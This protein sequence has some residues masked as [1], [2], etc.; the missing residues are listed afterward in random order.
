[1]KEE[2]LYA[3]IGV[4]LGA[5]LSSIGYLYR[6]RKARTQLLNRVLFDLLEIWHFTR[7]TIASG[8]HQL[9][10]VYLAAVQKRLPDTQFTTEEKLQL[11]GYMASV[12][13]HL[14]SKM[15][16]GFEHSAKSSYLL[17]VKELAREE[18][19]LA[20][21]LSGNANLMSLLDE[22]DRVLTA[23]AGV[24][25]N[26]DIQGLIEEFKE[27]AS[28]YM[29][30]EAVADLTRDIK[31]VA[32]KI[33]MLQWYRT[34]QRLQVNPEQ[35]EMKFQAYVEKLVA[36]MVMPMIEDVKKARTERNI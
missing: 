33:C 20:F 31:R 16:E 4:A 13:K 32:W 21:E 22:A 34:T 19:L 6:I 14:L 18:P 24:E 12:F 10:D 3:L 8:I 1:M 7:A 30:S 23:I 17:L 25:S 29:R 15:R 26:G 36:T 28:L 11:Q 35:E 5:A 2:Y 9:S 27:S